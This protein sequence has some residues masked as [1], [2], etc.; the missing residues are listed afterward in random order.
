M[1]ASGAA[2]A[3][4]ALIGDAQR[5]LAAARAGWRDDARAF[6][7]GRN[8]CFDLASLSKPWAATLALALDRRG[9]VPL[10]MSIGEALP[11][12]P[13][14]CGD[15]RL[16]DLLTHRSGMAAWRPLFHQ[17]R[18]GR[19]VERLLEEA[20][21]GAAKPT[22]SDL[23]YML[24][25]RCAE[26][27]SGQRLADLLHREVLRP[28]A[29]T[30]VET[31]PEL[32]RSVATLLDNRRE[33]ELA[34]AQGIRLAARGAPPPGTAQDGN[35]RFLGGF[36]G[37]AGLFAPARSLWR[38][39][40]EWLRPGRLLDAAAV[41]RAL[42][43]RGRYALGWWRRSAAPIAAEPLS[44]ASFGHHGFT[45]GSLWIDPERELVAVLLAHRAAVDTDLD[46]WRQRF[47]RLA[48][49]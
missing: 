26:R 16:A 22:Y 4:S 47:H 39:G 41:S 14:T 35:A 29:L 5:P 28:L 25:A 44:G 10:G 40:V 42:G 45:G 11:Q 20:S 15:K 27:S 33:V 8:D 37:H 3:V 36:P 34:A 23:G 30:T 9:S 21:W 17:G 32:Q 48:I 13:S 18:T 12:A 6:Q 7:L 49:A 31:A 1:V 2:T 46:P 43:G 19:L 38:L 24:W